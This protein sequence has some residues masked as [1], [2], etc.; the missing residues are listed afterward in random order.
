MPNQVVSLSSFDEKQCDIFVFS[1]EKKSRKILLFFKTK[2]R[3]SGFKYNPEV[4][5]VSRYMRSEFFDKIYSQEYLE[6]E[7]N[8]LV[9]G[10]KVYH[11]PYLELIT[12]DGSKY[13]IFESDSINSV[14]KK[15]KE[16]LIKIRNDQVLNFDL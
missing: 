7:K 2:Y 6:K 15:K 11:K 5:F 9:H 16:L 10:L 1:P 8:Y 3:K 13:R 4:F 12:T 14:E